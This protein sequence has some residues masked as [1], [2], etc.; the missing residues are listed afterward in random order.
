MHNTLEKF[1]RSAAPSGGAYGRSTVLGLTAKSKSPPFAAIRGVHGIDQCV[2]HA[3]HDSNQAVATTGIA[4][5]GTPTLCVPRD[6]CHVPAAYG[7][8]LG[9]VGVEQEGRFSKRNIH[10][11]YSPPFRFT[12]DSQ[13]VL[14]PKKW[15]RGTRCSKTDRN[16]APVLLHQCGRIVGVAA[17]L[18][19]YGIKRVTDPLPHPRV[20]VQTHATQ[21]KLGIQGV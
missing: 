19:A 1:C 7:T 14:T 12:I 10:V 3:Q 8:I 21:L 13:V 5:T 20:I 17:Q 11:F 15:R 6:H 2:L 16:A 4:T 18:I 9:R